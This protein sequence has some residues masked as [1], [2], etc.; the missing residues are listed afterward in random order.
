MRRQD[1]GQRTNPH[2]RTVLMRGKER[3]AEPAQDT[4]PA[5][6]AARQQASPPQSEWEDH[7][8]FLVHSGCGG[9]LHPAD[10]PGLR[11]YCDCGR[12]WHGKRGKDGKVSWSP[13][14]AKPGPGR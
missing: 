12:E 11:R 9:Y 6:P 13:V 2:G 14:G 10:I 8:G 4:P 1:D 3:V 5:R 7:G